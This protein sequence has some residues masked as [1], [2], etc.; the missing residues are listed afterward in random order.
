MTQLKS[1]PGEESSLT[2]GGSVTSETS[3][4]GLRPVPKKRTFLS[5]HASTVSENSGRG[6]DARV[7]SAAAVPAPRRSIQGGSSGSSGQSNM[8]EM[9]HQVSRPVQPINTPYEN[10]QQPFS[11]VLSNSSSERVQRPV[12]LPR[13]R[14]EDKLPSE[15][16]HKTLNECLSSFSRNSQSAC[17]S[18]QRAPGVIHPLTEATRRGALNDLMRQ[19]EIT[20]RWTRSPFTPTAFNIQTGKTQTLRRRSRVCLKVL[21]VSVTRYHLYHTFNLVKSVFIGRQFFSL[22]CAVK[23]FIC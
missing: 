16:H 9:P 12:S 3:S 18:G 8:D 20:Q 10:F 13:E 19:E 1:R 22:R 11:K 14:S 7:G 5:R 15:S 17:F 4:L 6:S 2:S 23:L 21:T